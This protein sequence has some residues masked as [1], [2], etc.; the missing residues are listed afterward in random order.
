[1][2][3]HFRSSFK[4]L[5]PDP[6]RDPKTLINGIRPETRYDGYLKYRNFTAGY[7]AS[8]ISGAYLH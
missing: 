6:D 8:R 4:F 3:Q 5:D 7:L 1:M 2:I